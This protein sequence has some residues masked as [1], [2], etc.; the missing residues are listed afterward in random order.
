MPPDSRLAAS[1]CMPLRVPC[2]RP[3]T[4]ASPFF[5]ATS[6]CAI[7]QHTEERAAGQRSVELQA[8]RRGDGER[9][10]RVRNAELAEGEVAEGEFGTLENANRAGI[11]MAYLVSAPDRV[12]LIGLPKQVA[13]RRGLW[14]GLGKRGEDRK[15]EL[16]PDRGRA[17]QRVLDIDRQAAVHNESVAVCR[18]VQGHATRSGDARC[19]RSDLHPR[20]IQVCRPARRASYQSGLTGGVVA[21]FHFPGDIAGLDSKRVR[22][23]LGMRPE[24]GKRVCQPADDR[25]SRSF[26]P[27]QQAASI[28]V[29][30][31]SE[32]QAAAVRLETH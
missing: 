31:R 32:T 16:L 6:P 4:D 17:G 13:L 20:D 19:T 2:T 8:V 9:D 24:R 7:H 25:C 26:G 3:V 15:L 23:G 28:G 1:A 21:C 11:G 18:E 22:G 27:G 10:G 30:R 29:N 5:Q 12:E 14:K